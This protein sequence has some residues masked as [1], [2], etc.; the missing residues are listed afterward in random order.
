ML[1]FESR[2]F[3]ELR[4]QGFWKQFFS[5]ESTGMGIF[6][7]LNVFCIQVK[8]Q[9][10]HAILQ[11]A[12]MHSYMPSCCL[13]SLS[14]L[15]T[16]RTCAQLVACIALSVT[17]LLKQWQRRLFPI[18]DICLWVYLGCHNTHS[19]IMMFH[20]SQRMGQLTSKRTTPDTCGQCFTMITHARRHVLTCARAC[21]DMCGHMC[22][23]FYLGTTR[24]QLEHKGDSAHVVTN[25]ANVVPAFGFIGIPVISWLLDKKG[26]G[27]TLA[28]INLLGVLASIFQAM[29][30]LP[31]QV[32]LP[33]L[34][35]AFE[36]TMFLICRAT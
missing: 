9:R 1:V 17:H 7:T 10:S 18:V 30:S 26:Y 16:A 6:Y 35:P 28:V 14:W 19:T 22:A 4:K 29:P 15:V 25:I 34:L 20:S 23:Q 13:C 12:R 3:V 21:A 31:F 36:R 5:A 27:V 33:A 2:R 8:P 32:L 11:H 24:L